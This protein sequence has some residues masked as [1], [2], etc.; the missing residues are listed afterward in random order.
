MFQKFQMRLAP[1]CLHQQ[2]VSLSIILA[3]YL[4]MAFTQPSSPSIYL[5]QGRRIVFHLYPF[6]LVPTSSFPLPESH[7]VSLHIQVVIWCLQFANFSASEQMQTGSCQLGLVMV[8]VLPQIHH[9]LQPS[10]SSAH[11][12]KL[13]LWA[14]CLSRLFSTPHLSQG[15]VLNFWPH[16]S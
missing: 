15:S 4:H 3:G 6:L 14:C 10:V 9:P 16:V 8:K 11:F 12:R 7:V 5:S 13:L 1:I 2:A